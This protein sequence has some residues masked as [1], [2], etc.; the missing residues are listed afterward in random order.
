MKVI[1]I[2]KLLRTFHGK[3]KHRNV[4]PF[5]VFCL[6]WKS[7]EIWEKREWI[8]M[9]KGIAVYVDVSCEY[10][11]TTFSLVARDS[12]FP[13]GHCCIFS[14][15]LWLLNCEHPLTFPLLLSSCSLLIVNSCFIISLPCFNYLNFSEC[16][17]FLHFA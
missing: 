4:F 12:H 8:K 7:W 13:N 9:Y 6:F 2:S 11:Q 3:N 1:T 16:L 14:A 10:V 15:W 5:I 17:L